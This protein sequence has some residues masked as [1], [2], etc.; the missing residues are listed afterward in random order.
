MKSNYLLR[1]KFIILNT[2]ILFVFNS[3]KTNDVFPPPNSQ[4]HY[5]SSEN[6]VLVNEHQDAITK[7]L[8]L[9]CADNNDILNAIYIQSGKGLEEYFWTSFKQLDSVLEL[10]YQLDFEQIMNDKL[11]QI[12]YNYSYDSIIELLNTNKKLHIIVPKLNE[13]TNKDFNDYKYL[14]LNNNDVSSLINPNFFSYNESVLNENNQFNIYRVINNEVNTAAFNKLYL[15]VEPLIIISNKIIEPHLL[16]HTLNASP[17]T[18]YNCIFNEPSCKICNE[19]YPN[20]YSITNNFNVPFGQ[21]E[22][23]VHAQDAG[24]QDLTYNCFGEYFTEDVYFT[25]QV[26]SSGMLSK[27]DGINYYH[28]VITTNSA[29]AYGVANPI[30]YN[31]YAS[32][33]DEKMFASSITLCKNSTEFFVYNGVYNNVPVLAGGI[34]KITRFNSLPIYFFFPGHIFGGILTNDSHDNRVNFGVVKSGSQC[35]GFDELNPYI[36]NSYQCVFCN[37]NILGLNYQYFVSTDLNTLK[38]FWYETNK[39]YVH[40][41]SSF[42]S[43]NPNNNNNLAIFNTNDQNNC[44][45]I[46]PSN[47]IKISELNYFQGNF[48]QAK[49]FDNNEVFG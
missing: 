3:C 1:I 9:A 27:V 35:D 5:I 26:P 12:E 18:I 28:N 8:S 46:L 40:I 39:L 49:V 36:Q 21:I 2:C 22:M 24:G 48:N 15:G 34:Y 47:Y 41:S 32:L 37:T 43:N 42:S 19:N 25:N 4:N 10:K 7:A 29:D 33:G 31:N 30:I 13:L 44:L 6:I 20:G 16:F 11:T 17:I 14:E 23:G 45:S 38:L